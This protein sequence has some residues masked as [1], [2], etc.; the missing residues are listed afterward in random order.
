V[1]WNDVGASGWRRWSDWLSVWGDLPPAA[2]TIID[3]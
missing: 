3:W 1:R 2:S